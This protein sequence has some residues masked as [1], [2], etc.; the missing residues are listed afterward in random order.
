[1]SDDTPGAGQGALPP[2]EGQSLRPAAVA[3]R[4]TTMRLT[5][6]AGGQYVLTTQPHGVP[7]LAQL[8]PASLS[9][10]QGGVTRIISISPSRGQTSPLRPSLTNQSIVNVL[11]RGNPNVRLQL[12]QQSSDGGAVSTASTSSSPSGNK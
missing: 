4:P 10:V 6:V 3:E 7:A 9:N 2:R 8:S 11:K 1:M 5:Q 12:F